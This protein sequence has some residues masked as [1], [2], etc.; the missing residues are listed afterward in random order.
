[1]HHGPP[2]DAV[3]PVGALGDEPDAGH[4]ASM[5]PPIG[6]VVG[7]R[8]PASQS[9][10]WWKSSGRHLFNPPEGPSDVEAMDERVGERSRR[11]H[12]ERLGTG[13]GVGPELRQDR[14]SPACGPVS[15]TVG[16]EPVDP[17]PAR[18]EPRNPAPGPMTGAQAR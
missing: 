3:R 12:A 15:R 13:L 1:M 7:H 6:T 14:G 4:P 9:A 10:T 17:D 5:L 11:R 16:D 18:A 2:A 8:A